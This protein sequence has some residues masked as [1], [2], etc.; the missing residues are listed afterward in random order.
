MSE[1]QERDSGWAL[2]KI[3]WL[4]LNLNKSAP[5]KGSQY[6][7]TPKSL[8]HKKACWNLKNNDKF[9]F[10][11]CLIA[12][13]DSTPNR[14]P[15]RTSSYTIPDIKAEK[16]TLRNG[17]TLNFEGMNFPVELKNISEF[18]TNNPE[19]SIN[20]F[21]YDK[22]VVGPL[23][24]TK[25]E[26]ANHVNLILLA[27]AD[28]AHF[29]LV[30]HVSR[31]IR[32]Q[33][34][35]NRR[36]ISICNSC[37]YCTPREDLMIIHKKYCSRVVTKMPTVEESI[38]EFKNFRKQMDVPFVI[39]ADFECVL[40][41]VIA[42][43]ERIKKHIPCAYGFNIKCS[44]DSSLDVY[45]HYTGEDAAQKFIEQ[46]DVSCREIYNNYLSLNTPMKPLSSIEQSIFDSALNCHICDKN[47][48]DDKVRDHCHVTGKFRGAAHNVCNINYTVAQFIPIFF[49]NFSE[50]D[51]HLFV[52]ELLT[53]IEGNT[54]IIPL[55]KEKY[56]SLSHTVN[57]N[58]YDR[59]KTFE[60]RFL[61]S[62][63]FMASSLDALDS[64]C[65]DGDMSIRKHFTNDN[66]FNL[67][68][69]KG[70]FCYEYLN[71][72]EKLNDTTLPPIE[73]FYSTLNDKRC[74][75]EEYEHAIKV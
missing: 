66:E 25:A 11:W 29:I 43:G 8:R 33:L 44:F 69:K 59:H 31:L 60:Y 10:K 46:L 54:T 32:S 62:I 53:T 41:T 13:M 30:K 21:G 22:E 52:K 42:G 15:T 4:E 56:I 48:Y 68:R 5:I 55:T 71:S 38:L 9:C 45:H 51:C 23:Y 75:I 18:E 28:K 72:F 16:I 12:A 7:N 1:F 37:F 61:D 17:V 39:Y 34:T 27:E 2:S 24:H 35:T 58:P 40:E 70:I 63:R 49:H 73:S 6:I 67:M 64:Y 36:K 50:Y 19:I 14:N 74:Y 3:L 26:K 20:V 47:L 57:M 65:T